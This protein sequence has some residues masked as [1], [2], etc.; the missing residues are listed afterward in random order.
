MKVI[1]KVESEEKEEAFSVVDMVLK[2][3]TFIWF[4]YPYLVIV[5][6][7]LELIIYSFM[8]D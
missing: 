1:V 4:K 7:N 3:M 8:N 5:K 2:E 6:G